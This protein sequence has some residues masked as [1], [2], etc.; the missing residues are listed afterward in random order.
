M[1]VNLYT[2]FAISQLF[3]VKK[4]RREPAFCTR[5]KHP[6]SSIK[7]VIIQR[8]SLL[9]NCLQKK[10][11]P[12]KKKRRKSVVLPITC[13]LFLRKSACAGVSYL[14][15]T[16]SRH[17]W[18]VTALLGLT[19]RAQVR[20]LA[21]WAF[22]LPPLPCLCEINSRKLVRRTSGLAASRAG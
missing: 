9:N 10:S 14:E 15:S 5:I 8:W 13:T 11:K 6:F 2:D 20:P 4:Q 16:D 19:D 12:D 7:N 22:L 21:S 18:L 17:C 1:L 3:P